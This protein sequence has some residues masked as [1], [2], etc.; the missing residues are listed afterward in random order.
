MQNPPPHP[1]GPQTGPQGPSYS[2]YPTQPTPYPPQYPPQ[3]PTY[4]SLYPSPQSVNVYFQN[5][6]FTNKAVIAFLLYWLGYVP[7]LIFN[8]MYLVEARRV[9]S[10]TGRTPSGYGCLWATLIG[11]LIPAVL[12]VGFCFLIFAAMAASGGGGGN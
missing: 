10:E 1:Q 2:P 7:G 8:I 4:P 5:Q 9:E 6:S 3:Q 12:F 11:S